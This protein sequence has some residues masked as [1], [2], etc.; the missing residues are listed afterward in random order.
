M[1]DRRPNRL[2][3]SIGYL[4]II[5]PVPAI[6]LFSMFVCSGPSVRPPTCE[7][8]IEL[9]DQSRVVVRD[10]GSINDV[11]IYIDASVPMR[12]FVRQNDTQDKTLYT[13]LLEFMG[14]NPWGYG[15][16]VRHLQFG[17]GDP[18][19]IKGGKQTLSLPANDRSFY[20][21]KWTHLGELVSDIRG[22][23]TA[24]DRAVRV[25]VTDLVQ[26]NEPSKDDPSQSNWAYLANNIRESLRDGGWQLLG[27]QSLYQGRHYPES[28]G[29]PFG[30]PEPVD[31]PFYLMIF[32]PSEDIVEKVASGL[33]G[34]EGTERWRSS[35][36]RFQ[37][38]SQM[39]Q[40][41][42][43]QSET[44]GY[45]DEQLGL[46]NRLTMR[47]ELCDRAI[48]LDWIDIKNRKDF[49][50]VKVLLQLA[51]DNPSESFVNIQNPTLLTTVSCFDWK[52]ID[53]DGQ[54]KPSES[55]VPEYSISP[56]RRPQSDTIRDLYQRRYWTEFRLKPSAGMRS[57]AYYIYRFTVKA[58]PMELRLPNWVNEWST[59]EDG[60]LAMIGRTLNLKRILGSVVR[61][62]SAD[63]PLYTGFFVVLGR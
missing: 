51:S 27:F 31:R 49:C 57:S 48:A 59:D 45:I 46:R 12:N 19:P 44:P 42:W 10:D 52:G 17:E 63:E 22:K 32:G 6:V 26:A 28:G 61:A 1:S 56:L 18:R 15:T 33:L 35:C 23:L 13:E 47:E 55:L 21:Q 20:D 2:Y 30:V 43:L 40:I 4:A 3:R 38:K 50:N 5:V 25:V 9:Y 7:Q 37:P 8:I 14:S 34:G 62:M 16:S 29:A 58:D 36:R 60:S 53:V 41:K 24:G 39:V 54:V 11:E